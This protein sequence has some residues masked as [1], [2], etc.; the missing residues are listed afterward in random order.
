[1]NENGIIQYDNVDFEGIIQKS[2]IVGENID[3]LISTIDSF[4]QNLDS[5]IR[6]YYIEEDILGNIDKL[7]KKLSDDFTNADN[8]YNWIKE[9]YITLQDT[10][11]QTEKIA[12]TTGDSNLDNSNHVVEENNLKTISSS[13]SEN[14][15]EQKPTDSA[16]L[17]GLGTAAV[18]GSVVAFGLDA[19]ANNKDDISDEKNSKQN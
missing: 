3:D 6:E 12:N 1:M 8:F 15:F 18:G 4:I 17:I 13:A 19:F 9:G 16:T 7:K 5:R 10:I 11:H 2:L 14:F